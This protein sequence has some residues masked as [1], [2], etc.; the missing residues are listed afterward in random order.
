[1]TSNRYATPEAF[2]RALSTR[3]LTLSRTQTIDY[4]RLRREV[5]YDRFLARLQAAAPGRWLLKGGVALDLRFARGEAR[6]TKDVDLETRIASTLEEATEMLAGAVNADLGDFLVFAITRKPTTNI[7]EGIP[8]YR[9]G[10]EV[11]INKRIFETFSCDIG[12]ANENIGEPER[13]KGRSLLGF[14]GIES[15]EVLA[16]PLNRH[17]ADK[18][19]AYVRIHNGVASSRAKD[20]VDLALVTSYRAVAS[21]G[22]LRAALRYVFEGHNAPLPGVFPEPPKNWE[23]SYP[24][25]A[26]GIAVSGDMFQAY[27]LVAGLLD[28]VL[29]NDVDPLYHWNPERQYWEAPGP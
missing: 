5:V 7:F 26:D 29:A 15:V 27:T 1:M 24:I 6:R 18:L 9:F 21:A 20:L 12:V 10:I 11:R 17:I 8:A 22:D 14:A 23:K 28:P 13:V 2:E 16:V 4:Q 25:A 3:L 19:H